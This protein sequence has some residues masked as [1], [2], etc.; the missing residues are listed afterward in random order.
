MPGD[1]PHEKESILTDFDFQTGAEVAEEL[2]SRGGFRRTHWLRLSDGESITVR[3]YTDHNEIITILMHMNVPT[4]PG[5]SDAKNWPRTMA[6]VC[7]NAKAF[8]GAFP[9]C[10]VCNDVA[11]A[12]DPKKSPLHARNRTWGIFIERKEVTDDLGRVVSIEDVLEEI[13]GEDGVKRT[14]PKFLVASNSYD[15]FW[16]KM[17][18]R[19]QMQ[20]TWT[21]VDWRI[22]RQG[23]GLD[24]DYTF[25]QHNPIQGK[26]SADGEPRLMSMADPEIKAIYSEHAPVLS[27]LIV[28]QADDE[29][30]ARFFDLRMP[31]PETK[32]SD[33]QAQAVSGPSND[34]SVD[35]LAALASRVMS[36]DTAPVQAATQPVAAVASATPVIPTLGG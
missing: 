35:Q 10:S 22:T 18:G 3:P 29:Y 27:D 12:D 24:T 5:P 13:E 25:G 15:N 17:I 23:G 26:L 16:S 20:G 28:A 30:Y 7:R 11:K 19:S 1:R 8:K 34:V 31:F 14:I 33:D 4:R 21:D 32:K 2:S 6:G 36:P 9:D